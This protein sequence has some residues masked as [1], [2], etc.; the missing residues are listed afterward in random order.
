M[1]P[2][3]ELVGKVE[4]DCSLSIHRAVNFGPDFGKLVCVCVHARARACVGGTR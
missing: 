3:V 1:D 4:R 2:Y